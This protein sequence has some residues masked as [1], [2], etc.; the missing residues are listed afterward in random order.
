MT[1]TSDDMRWL[2]VGRYHLITAWIPGALIF[3][4]AANAIVE[5]RSSVRN[6]GSASALSVAAGSAFR[7]A[8]P[9]AT[10]HVPQARGVSLSRERQPGVTPSQSE[11]LAGALGHPSGACNLLI[12]LAISMEK[13]A[14]E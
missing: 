14:G 5:Y 2:Y 10:R 6:S 9:I 11:W 8:A 4:I 12:F 3:V 1:M 7:S 13:L